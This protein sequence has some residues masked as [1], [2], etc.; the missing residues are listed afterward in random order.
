MQF[1]P[2]VLDLIKGNEALL[3]AYQS[4]LLQDLRLK[5]LTLKNN[6]TSLK[7]KIVKERNEKNKPKIN[8]EKF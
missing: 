4:V 2:N 8:T 5:E 3:K 1:D 6:Y 7:M